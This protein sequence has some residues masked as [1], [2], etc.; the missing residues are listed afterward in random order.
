MP[1]ATASSEIVRT[2]VIH[3]KCQATVTHET[4]TIYIQLLHAPAQIIVDSI[5]N[6]NI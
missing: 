2:E 1:P 4:Y 3:L 5:Q 6:S